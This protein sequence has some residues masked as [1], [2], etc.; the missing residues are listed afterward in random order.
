M[1]IVT[2]DGTIV[3]R[4]N[5]QSILPGVTRASLQQFCQERQMRFEERTFTIDEV[6]NAKEAFI[7]AA[8]AFVTP[9]VLLDGK[10]I[11]DGNVGATATAL[12]RLYIELTQSSA[13]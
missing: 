9:V 7:T 2:K 6:R 1:W 4:P 11:G 8:S 12:Q 10:P 3:T 13:I 5:S